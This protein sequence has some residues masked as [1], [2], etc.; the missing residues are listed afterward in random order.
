MP[1]VFV[2]VIKE[3]ASSSPT[4]APP[5]RVVAAMYNDGVSREG[6]V[7]GFGAFGAATVNDGVTV[8]RWMWMIGEAACEGV[9]SESIRSST[10]RIAHTFS[11]SVLRIEGMFRRMFMPPEVEAARSAVIAAEKT[12]EVPLMHW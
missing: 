10:A 3:V 2:K 1:K 12:K 11:C 5:S 9:V 6:A 8:R 7:A 4:C